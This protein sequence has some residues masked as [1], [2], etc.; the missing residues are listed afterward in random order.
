MERER[1]E[2][3]ICP[4]CGRFVG[5]HLVCP[6]CRTRV[7]KRMSVMLFKYGALAVAFL[8]LVLLY[9]AVR[10]VKIPVVKV[11]DIT[12]TMNF[13]YV[14]VVGTVERADV[15]ERDTL[16]LTVDD[17]TGSISARSHGKVTEEIMR[18]D[19]P[20]RL[21]D[22]I[23]VGGTLNITEDKKVL[24]IQTPDRVKVTPREEW[25]GKIPTFK[26]GDIT[27]SKMGEL[28]RCQG[29]ITNIRPLKK[30]R[31]LTIDDGSGSIDVVIWDTDYEKIPNREALQP[32]AQISVQGV[33]GSF[34]DKLQIKPLSPEEI[35]IT[36]AREEVA[37]APPIAVRVP[38]LAV[39]QITKDRIGQTVG[40]QGT[41]TQYKPFAK[42]AMLVVSDE[43]GRI[44]VVLW[45]KVKDQITDH[46]I[47]TV[48]NRVSV[49]GKVEIYREQLQLVPQAADDIAVKGG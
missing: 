1:K 46:R 30:G 12:E 45:D 17:G 24:L 37:V 31:T 27:R 23:D 28:A 42:G 40:C 32:H 7:P 49:R 4:S 13:A 6:Y 5:A 10:V 39:G 25:I 21:G 41:V 8:G 2:E 22:R 11:K 36:R 19:N 18:M 33:I 44:V 29:E 43:T 20:P 14:R 47:F 9:L 3:V 26:I 35:K 48:G 16:Y 15:Y 38:T 34:R